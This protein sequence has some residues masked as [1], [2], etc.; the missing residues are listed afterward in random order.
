MYDKVGGCR[1]QCKR[2]AGY[3]GASAAEIEE[4][5]IGAWLLRRHGVRSSYGGR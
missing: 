1:R 2:L 3:P 4:A 5:E